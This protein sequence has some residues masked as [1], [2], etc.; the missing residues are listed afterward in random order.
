ML[1]GEF[2]ELIFVGRVGGIIGNTVHQLFCILLGGG[3][4]GNPIHAS[5]NGKLRVRLI[6]GILG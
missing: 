6:L 3:V 4:N 1:D 5:R 2:G